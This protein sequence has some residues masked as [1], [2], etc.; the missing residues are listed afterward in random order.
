M[1]VRFGRTGIGWRKALTV[2]H[3]YVSLDEKSGLRLL[4]EL[5]GNGC[6]PSGSPARAIDGRVDRH[7]FFPMRVRSPMVGRCYIKPLPDAAPFVVVGSR[8]H[9]RT[10]VVCLIEA[11]SLFSEIPA[12]FHGVVSQVSG[13]KTEHRSSTTQVLFRVSRPSLD[14]W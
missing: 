3:P 9:G 2:A 1:K 13:G 8:V 10:R 6:S 14:F 4:K 12:G 7:G 11:M 5:G